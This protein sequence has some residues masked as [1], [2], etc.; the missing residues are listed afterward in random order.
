MPKNRLHCHDLPLF[1]C[2]DVPTWLPTT[3]RTAGPRY[4]KFYIFVIALPWA[5]LALCSF[6]VLNLP[7][8]SSNFTSFRHVLLN[9]S[10]LRIQSTSLWRLCGHT[11]LLLQLQRLDPYNMS[12]YVSTKHLDN[13]IYIYIYNYIY[14]IL[15]MNELMDG[16][17]IFHIWLEMT[18][19]IMTFRG[20]VLMLTVS[21]ATSLMFIFCSSCKVQGHFPAAAFIAVFHTTTSACSWAWEMCRR[22]CKAQV[23]CWASAQTLMTVL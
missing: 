6:A 19:W 8:S 10:L 9:L 12:E 4:I 17:P 20:T 21:A 18:C 22:K 7:P 5:T 14:T 11:E 15:Y 13:K 23:H 1:L 16:W 3:S 2:I